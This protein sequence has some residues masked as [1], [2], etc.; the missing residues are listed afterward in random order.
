[1]TRLVK[2]DASLPNF[3]TKELRCKGSGKLILA[4]GFGQALQGLRDAL[5]E[6][7]PLNSACRSHAHNIEVGGHP[8]SLHVCDL[9]HW[10]T[11]GTCA[12][13]VRF[14]EGVHDKLRGRLVALAWERGWSIG[15]HESF[16]HLDL[17]TEYA[18]LVQA[19]FSY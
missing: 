12:V 16:I 11:G 4:P 5:G 2:V 10:P 18:G 7:M 3:S 17:R 14:V 6:A 19:E 1:M 15:F 8:R 13:D 9:P